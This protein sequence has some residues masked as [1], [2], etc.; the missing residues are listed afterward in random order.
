MAGIQ[1]AMRPS[2]HSKTVQYNPAVTV[3]ACVLVKFPHY[4]DGIITI[5]RSRRVVSLLQH[6]HCVHEDNHPCNRCR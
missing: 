2:P 6:L 3:T 1:A 4:W 5:V